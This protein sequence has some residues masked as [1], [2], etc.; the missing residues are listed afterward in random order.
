MNVTLVG[1]LLFA[2]SFT[3]INLT[4]TNNRTRDPFAVNIIKPRSKRFY[5]DIE[6]T[7]EF[8]FGTTL[9]S[10]FD[11]VLPVK[12]TSRSANNS[13]GVESCHNKLW[14]ESWCC[15]AFGNSTGT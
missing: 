12:F 7:K 11:K 10:Y 15:S 5:A 13:F 6:E 4:C 14:N 2:G 1:F 8:L 9:L 3:D